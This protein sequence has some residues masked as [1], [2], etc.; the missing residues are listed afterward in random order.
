VIKTACVLVHIDQWNRIEDTEIKP[1][2]FMENWPLTKKLYNGK[3]KA[4]SING[5]G[6]TGSLYLEK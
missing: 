5:N 1:H 2:T 3:R 4:S 6:L